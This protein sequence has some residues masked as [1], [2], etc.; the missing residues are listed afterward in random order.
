MSPSLL[1]TSAFEIALN[2]YL[3][4]DPDALP[5]VMSFSGKVIALELVL[6]LSAGASPSATSRDPFGF[7]VYL[8]PG[9]GSIQ[10]I[11]SY[12]GVP[13]VLI[14]G[15]PFALARQ[16]G[17]GGRTVM[18][19]GV[20][21]E[22]DV[23]LGNAFRQLLAE[24]DIDWEEQLSRLIGDVAAHQFS[25]VVRRFNAWGQQA[26]DT[27]FKN[28]A[29]YPDGIYRST[30]RWQAKRDTRDLQHYA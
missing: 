10:V 30:K 11:D 12:S 19:S 26:L 3:Q 1:A 4:L 23:Q 25:N 2:R 6:G 17:E 16:A 9:P 14:R 13:D 20:E 22:G 29:E 18:N 21:L 7:T 27:L 5:R 24:V 15:T 28:T 8:L